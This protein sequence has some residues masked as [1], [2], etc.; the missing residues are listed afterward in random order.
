LPTRRK[1]TGLSTRN[2][3]KVGIY[4][5][6]FPAEKLKPQIRHA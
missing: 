3:V 5:P 4:S 2:I 6:L 1:P